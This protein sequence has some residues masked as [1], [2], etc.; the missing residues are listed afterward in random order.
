[1]N[2]VTKINDNRLS[3]PVHGGAT[4]SES[5]FEGIKAASSDYVLIH[6]GA[7]PCLPI[8]AL[9]RIITGLEDNDACFLALPVADTLWSITKD[10]VQKNIPR[11]M[12]WKAQT[13]QAFK[14]NQIYNAYK[15]ADISATDDVVIAQSAGIEVKP[16]LGTERNI[17]ITTNEDFDLAKQILGNTMDI[18]VG[19]GFDVHALGVGSQVVLNGIEIAHTNALMGHSDADV[20]MHAITDAIFG[21]LSEGDIG[22][23]FPP[24]DQKWKNASSDIFL[25][26]AVLLCSEREF[27]INHIDCTI[28]CETPKIGPYAKKM[29]ENISKITNVNVENISIKA[30]TTEK[31]GFTGRNEGIAAQATATLIRK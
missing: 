16:I 22:Q 2:M 10:K 31:L 28:I 7:R 11:N 13:P 9:D 5:V 29:C 20:A 21:A 15:N 4:R 17:K 25:R 12:I 8:D 1:M 24:S 19:N 18:R 3:E 26:K 6:D 27:Y 30:T 23:W 14:L